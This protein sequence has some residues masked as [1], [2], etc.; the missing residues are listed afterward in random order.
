MLLQND[1]ARILLEK[2]EIHAPVSDARFAAHA[3]LDRGTP[4]TISCVNDLM[5]GPLITLGHGRFRASHACP[6]TAESAAGI[7]GHMHEAGLLPAAG[8][9]R[10]TLEHLL[11]RASELYVEENLERMLLSPVYLREND[12][13][14]GGIQMERQSEVVE[15]RRLTPDAHDKGAVFAHRRTTP[16]K[17]PIKRSQP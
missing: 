4:L 5:H 14:I 11:M 15:H 7:A 10:K 12:Y 17:N 9:E 6:L 8:Q 2:H 1:E 13:R 16:P 3:R